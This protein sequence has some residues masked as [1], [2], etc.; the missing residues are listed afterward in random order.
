MV[1]IA[2]TVESGSHDDASLVAAF[3]GGD[4]EA[5]VALVRRYN[6]LLVRVACR[7][8]NSFAV[9]EEVAQETWI[10][11]LKSIDGFEG[12]AAFRTWLMTVLVNC[13]R[14]RA[15]SERRAVPLATLVD[16]DGDSGRDPTDFFPAD[17]SRWAGMWTTCVSNWADIPDERF[18]AAETQQH[19]RSAID[20]LPPAHRAVI[21]LRD[22]CGLSSAEVCDL[23]ELTE[24]NA[25]VL[26]H[27][28]RGRVRR[29]L[30]QYVEAP[31]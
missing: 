12:R 18:L 28:A 27:R 1:A 16:G 26:L 30:A 19:V 5:F 25:R 10:A 4:E 17:H 21:T 23:L 22:I 7:Y 15:A 29:A 24:G 13:A 2:N 6:G 11:V 31:C 8:T 9:A 14:R 3:R 20:E